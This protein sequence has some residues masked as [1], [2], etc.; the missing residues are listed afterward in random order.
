[1]CAAPVIHLHE[2]YFQ[3][4]QVVLFDITVFVKD[5]VVGHVLENHKP[6]ECVRVE[7]DQ[8]GKITLRLADDNE[9][10]G[11]RF[12]ELIFEDDHRKACKAIPLGD[13]GFMIWDNNIR[14]KGFDPEAIKYTII[15]QNLD[16]EFD[17]PY[18][19]PIIINE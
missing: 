11:Y 4:R 9:T 14:G 1:M 7:R 12:L 10:S 5:G 17:T 15:L 8:M 3:E 19:D 18:E 13:R 6:G 16:D 2:E